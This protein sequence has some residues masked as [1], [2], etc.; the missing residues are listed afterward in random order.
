VTPLKTTRPGT[1]M[2]G[3]RSRPLSSK[4]LARAGAQARVNDIEIGRQR[5]LRYFP[6]LAVVSPAVSRPQR[7]VSAAA[8]RAVSV[9]QKKR[10]A[11]WRKRKAAR[12]RK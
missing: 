11:E 9:A 6:G 8:R 5:L 10:W 4:P 1:E 3:I 7:V 2:V 12:A